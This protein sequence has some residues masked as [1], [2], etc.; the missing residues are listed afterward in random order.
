MTRATRTGLSELAWQYGYHCWPAFQRQPDRR[1]LFELHDQ[2]DDTRPLQFELKGRLSDRTL[3]EWEIAIRQRAERQTE[4]FCVECAADRLTQYRPIVGRPIL[5]LAGKPVRTCI[6][7]GIEGECVLCG[8]KV[9][10]F[11]EAVDE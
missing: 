5:L 1:F 2:G 3:E 7:A 8:A 4:K 9:W 10:G 11:Y 6:P